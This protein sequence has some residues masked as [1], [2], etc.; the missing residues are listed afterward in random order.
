M[1]KILSFDIGGT[2]IKY[3]TISKDLNIIEHNITD[4][5]PDGNC[6]KTIEV[7]NKIFL[8]FNNIDAVSIG[9]PGIV[10]Y[11]NNIIKFAPNLLNWQNVEIGNILFKLWD[12]PVLVDNDAN[13]FTY[14][15]THLGSGKASK[16]VLGITLGTG[17][18]SGIVFNGEI[19]RGVNYSAGELGH[20]IL[21]P[22][23]PL[24]SCGRRGC[25]ESLVSKNA[26]RRRLL[27]SIKFGAQ[28]ICT[29]DDDPD[30][31]YNAALKGDELACE[32]FSKSGHYLGIAIANAVNFFDFDCVVI[33][34]GITGSY[35]LMLPSLQRS[36]NANLI[37]FN[38]RNLKI[39]RSKLNENAALLGGALLMMT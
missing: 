23:G 13:L 10:D 30:D 8:S 31:I 15:E 32:I 35:D 7:L 21:L 9:F 20:C 34:G 3:A 14:A 18:G 39:T 4:T 27:N 12:K 16:A 28:T 25:L 6:E 24:C 26:I 37:N 2:R 22:D 36:L 29:I 11:K 5:P 1:K 38:L 33:G 17:V 19:Y